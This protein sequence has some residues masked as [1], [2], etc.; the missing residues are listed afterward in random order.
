MADN[1]SI[2]P[3]SGASFSTDDVGGVHYQRIKLDLGGDGLASPLV[4]G[5]QSPAN[6]IPVVLPSE[7]TEGDTDATITGVAILWED[8][9]NTL[10]AVSTAK[11][12]PVLAV[13]T[14][15]R[16]STTVAVSASQTGATVWDPATGKSFVITHMTVSLSVGGTIAIFDGT[17]SSAYIV[18]QGTLAANGGVDMDFASMHWQSSAADA[19]LKYTSGTGTTGHITVHGYE[20]AA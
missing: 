4:R 9:S 12:L 14:Q 10:R 15:T 18:F 5:Q 7:Y 6:S 13:E 8:A 17:N 11:P 1:V 16:V 3:G 19:I 20:V 2:T